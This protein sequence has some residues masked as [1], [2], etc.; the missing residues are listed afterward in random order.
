MKRKANRTVARAK[1]SVK[2]SLSK[3]QAK[4]VTAIV[5]RV[6]AKS[7]ETKRFTY[8]ATLE[9][10]AGSITTYNL[11]YHGVTRGLG[12]SDMTGD[13]LH[14]RGIKIKFFIDNYYIGGTPPLVQSQTQP[15]NIHFMIVST[16]VW[17]E[18]TSLTYGEIYD[19]A[20]PIGFIDLATVNDSTKVLYKKT[21]RCNYDRS[22][23]GSGGGLTGA[24]AKRMT[25]SI[26][27]KRNQIIKFLDLTQNKKLKDRNYYFVIQPSAL[28]SGALCHIEF[29]WQNYFKDS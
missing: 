12:V 6:Q 13:A 16:P 9:P 23:S 3:P 25:G 4:A 28:Q 10:G 22:Q 24:T 15:F 21:V 20:V 19:S 27:L 5:K 17:R 8:N 2:K 26:W 18:T 7:E 14:W 1:K 29:A 11:F